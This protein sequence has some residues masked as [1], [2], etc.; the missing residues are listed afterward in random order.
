[1]EGVEGR[2]AAGGQGS[3][4]GRHQ[5]CHQCGGTPRAYRR[6][7]HPLRQAGRARE[8]ARRYRLRLRTRAVLSAGPPPDH[9]GKNRGAR[10]GRARRKQDSVAVIRP[11]RADTFLHYTKWFLYSS[12]PIARS[13]DQ[14]PPPRMR[15]NSAQTPISSGYSKPCVLQKNPPLA[16]VNFTATIM[17][18]STA[19]A[20]KRVNSPST[21]KMPPIN[22]VQ[23]TSVPQNMPGVKPMRS[24]RATLPAKPMPPKAPNSFCMPWGI[25][26]P[27]STMRK[28]GS[29]YS[30]TAL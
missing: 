1:M 14:A 4:S 27:P 11:S 12:R 15:K 6:A 20:A 22:S 24:N 21:S 16:E 9:V 19:A 2:H 17:K 25:R 30:F 28:I 7:H 18:I 3:H 26:T 23:P 8:C 13:S 5:P 10:G 29:A